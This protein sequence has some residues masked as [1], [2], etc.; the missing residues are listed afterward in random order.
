ML[1]REAA[2]SVGAVGSYG[3]WLVRRAATQAGHTVH[4]KSDGGTYDCELVSVHHCLDFPRL[5]RMKKIAPIRIV[6]GHPLAAN[7]RPVIP[8]ADVVL[9]G[10]GEEWIVDALAVLAGG[11]CAEDLD[12]MT[13][14]IVTSNWTAGDDLPRPV[15][16]RR[17][18]A[19]EPYLAPGGEGH[20]RNWYIE[21]ARG[22]PYSCK[23]CS[24]GNLAPYRVKHRRDVIAELDMVDR[25]QSHKVT[26]MAPDEASHPGMAQFLDALKPRRLTSMF[27]S[28]RIEQIEKHSIKPKPNM[29]IRMGID[30]LSERLRFDTGKKI[31]NSHIIK[32]FERMHDHANF[33]FF[34][35]IG[36]PGETEADWREWADVMKV[37][38]DTPRKAN[39]HLRIKWTPLMPQPGTPY[40]DVEIQYPREM[41]RRVYEWHGQHR[42]PLREPGFYVRQDG[43]VMGPRGWKKQIELAHGDEDICA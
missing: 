29:L 20:A 2:E 12:G 1:A 43:D 10:E 42:I 18:P 30:G 22:C 11:G 31:T 6:G 9:L 35:I 13:G 8:H 14:T 25:S 24:L 26:F 39:G 15:F 28:M 3:F 16:S 4:A 36:Y 27:G 21:V 40:E 32:F 23:F 34:M 17:L 37:V 33:K 38:L 5:A 19:T 41:S 7:P